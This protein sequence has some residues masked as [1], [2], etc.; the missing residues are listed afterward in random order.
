MR[1]LKP[2]RLGVIIKSNQLPTINTCTINTLNTTSDLLSQTSCSIY[3]NTF[4][5]DNIMNRFHLTRVAISNDTIR[6]V[7]NHN[8]S[9]ADNA[10]LAYLHPWN[11]HS[12][13]PNPCTFS[14]C[15]ITAQSSLRRNVRKIVYFTLMVD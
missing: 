1:Y 12:R 15:D 8:A 2:N 3:C 14:H 11:N 5:I 7:T 6:D 9:S 4:G 10:P 13:S